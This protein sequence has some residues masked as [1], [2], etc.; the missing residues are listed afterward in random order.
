MKVTQLSTLSAAILL[1]TTA[2]A[3]SFIDDGSLDIELRNYSQERASEQ[4]NV[5]DESSSQWAQAIRADY[6]S[7]YF[8]NIIGIDL[9]AYYAVK[10]GASNVDANSNPGV[11]PV[12][13]EGDSGNY[14]KTG[15][16]I[17]VNL[18]DQGVLKYGRMQLDTPLI[19][20][21]DDRA[22]PSLTE[23]LYGNIAYQGLSAHLVWATKSNA[24]TESGFTDYTMTDS[25]NDDK[26]QPVKAVGG[27]YDFG[28]GLALS[29]DYATQTD[30]AK[31]YLTEA[32]YSSEMNGMGYGLAAQYA[33]LTYQGTT[34]DN[35]D[36]LSAD[37]NISTWGLKGNLT[38]HQAK[39]GLAYTKVSDADGLATFA[40]S[41]V[42]GEQDDTDYFGYNAVHYGDFNRRAQKAIGLSAGYDFAGIVDG[43]GVSAIYVTSDFKSGSEELDEKEYNLSVKYAFPQIKGLTAQLTYAENTTENIGGQEDTVKKDTVVVVKYNVAVF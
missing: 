29:A 41:W 6:S 9:N 15:Y 23:A 18:M 30:F 25:D 13:T 31:K 5:H 26:K 8:E 22:L 17:K 20:D 37:D 21:S 43:L 2:Q 42:G 12:D 36:T 10:L 35:L 4:D 32:T 1:A 19:N 33:K 24:K 38:V 11:L 16:A 28:S 39:L 27:A 3:N 14:G 7:G 40:S 34:K